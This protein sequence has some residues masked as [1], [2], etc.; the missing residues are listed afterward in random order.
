MSEQERIDRAVAIVAGSVPDDV[1]GYRI[2]YAEK[3]V[4][5]LVDAGLLNVREVGFEVHEARGCATRGTIYLD[6]RMVFNGVD[7]TAYMGARPAPK[8]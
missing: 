6:G 8:E 7:Y 4:Q 3:A 2:R 5:D 1:P